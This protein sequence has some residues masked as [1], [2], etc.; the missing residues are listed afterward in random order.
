MKTSNLKKIAWVFFALVVTTGTVLGQ[1]WRSGNRNF[2][3][4]NGSCLTSISGL[5]EDQQNQIQSMNEK[6]WKT[7]DELRTQRRSI[8]NAIEKS[9]IRTTMLKTVEAHRN[10]VKALLTEDQQ[11]QYNRLYPT[12]AY[13]PNQ[14]VGNR[15]GNGR[16]SRQGCQYARGN[17]CNGTRQMNGRGNR[18]GNQNIRRGTCIYN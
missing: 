11:N 10:A 6:H 13:G 8:T 2:N 5:T 7:M 15:G 9:E 4:Q 17:S 18:G 1:G 16:Y 3:G 14:N 12:V